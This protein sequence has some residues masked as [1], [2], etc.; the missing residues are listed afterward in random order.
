MIMLCNMQVFVCVLYC[1]SYRAMESTECLFGGIKDE[2]EKTIRYYH[3]LQSTG[4][5]SCI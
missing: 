3:L 5:Y 1:S 2:L 4:F